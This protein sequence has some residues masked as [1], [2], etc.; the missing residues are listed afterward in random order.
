MTP[1]DSHPATLRFEPGPGEAALVELSQ[2]FVKLHP[3]A[4]SNKLESGV[5]IVGVLTLPRGEIP[6]S[7][8]VERVG[9]DGIL[10]KLD[11]LID[12]YASLLN[13][14]MSELQLLDFVI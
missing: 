9:T 7:G 4:V 5:E 10:V 1:L 3:R 11:M 12:E 8:R 2:G 14:Y 13:R 6:V